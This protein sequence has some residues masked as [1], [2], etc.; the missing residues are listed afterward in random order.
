MSNAVYPNASIFT[1]V[2]NAAPFNKVLDGAE[3]RLKKLGENVNSVFKNIGN[4]ADSPNV[5]A[6][7]SAARPTSESMAFAALSRQQLNAQ[8]KIVAQSQD[9]SRR[10]LN[11]ARINQKAALSEEKNASDVLRHVQEKVKEERKYRRQEQKTQNS[12]TVIQ[13]KI[14][15]IYKEVDNIRLRAAQADLRAAKTGEQNA[16]RARN[17][18]QNINKGQ[19]K[20]PKIQSIGSNLGGGNIVVSGTNNAR[21]RLNPVDAFATF[22]MAKHYAQAAVSPLIKGAEYEK[23][24][25]L[26]SKNV[27]D[28]YFENNP[29]YRDSNG[30][31]LPDRVKRL[32]G[33][34][35]IN[36]AIV[37]IGA[38]KYGRSFQESQAVALALTKSDVAP[39]SLSEMMDLVFSM[40]LGAEVDTDTAIKFMTLGQQNIRPLIERQALKANPNLKN[41]REGLRKATQ[42]GFVEEMK[43]LLQITKKYPVNEEEAIIALGKAAPQLEGTGLPMGA[44]HHLIMASVIKANGSGQKGGTIAMRVGRMGDM[45]LEDKKRNKFFKEMY[46]AGISQNQIT[47]I[48]KVYQDILNGKLQYDYLHKTAGKDLAG[49]ISGKH[50]AAMYLYDEGIKLA[51]NAPGVQNAATPGDV[52]AEKTM[53]KGVLADRNLREGFWISELVKKYPNATSIED[54]LMKEGIIQ[55][56]FGGMATKDS[57]G[58]YVLTDKANQ[59]RITQDDITAFQQTALTKGQNAKLYDEELKVMLESKQTIIDRLK[60]MFGIVQAESG[61]K[62]MDMGGFTYVIKSWTD[63]LSGLNT[64][65]QKFPGIISALYTVFATMAA[66][67][68]AKA[69]GKFAKLPFQ[70]FR[71]GSIFSMAKSGMPHITDVEG[72]I[73]GRT[74]K[75]TDRNPFLPK[76][77]KNSKYQRVRNAGRVGGQLLLPAGIAALTYFGPEIAEA[78]KKD[79]KIDKNA[80]VF[81]KIPSYAAKGASAAFLSPMGFPATMIALNSTGA[82]RGGAIGALAGQGIHGAFADENGKLFGQNASTFAGSGATIGA[83][84]PALIS[85][86]IIGTT[87]TA[88]MG[89][90]IVSLAIVAAVDYFK[91]GTNGKIH[92]WAD[93]NFN[94]NENI[95]IKIL[96]STKPFKESELTKDERI[97]YDTVHQLGRTQSPLI[98]LQPLPT[99]ES[100]TGINTLDSNQSNVKVELNVN[101]NTGLGLKFD[102]KSSGPGMANFP[103]FSK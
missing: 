31:L 21:D 39:D 93:K 38:K 33:S 24:N 67:V 18:I 54:M 64:I 3:A 50:A 81:N 61:M 28:Y 94:N 25:L 55:K 57:K 92:Q 30:K 88:L 91:N 77:K 76:D 62:A 79:G 72:N 80:S 4:I 19:D 53:A 95:L 27:P 65:I 98:P 35:L 6:F 46:A 8:S 59:Q 15:N 49:G 7:N 45:L 69:L 89:A 73:G 51:P 101:N 12:R 90:G 5:K 84:I 9:A 41:D 37:N 74:T 63:F 48:E 22:Y 87:I 100:I 13:G 16:S 42:A 17:T 2:G 34:S 78:L 83:L 99:L 75:N 47:D 70:V 20:N 86:G 40:Q 56:G 44:L 29:E 14:N 1:L 82:I 23:G 52:G 96:K 60:A 68:G 103:N 97:N 32:A 10:Q 102:S 26:I 58:K 85:A 66:V 11:A 71:G 36:N 43:S